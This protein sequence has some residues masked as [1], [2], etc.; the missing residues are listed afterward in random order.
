MCEM[1]GRSVLTEYAHDVPTPLIA[2]EESLALLFYEPIRN[3]ANDAQ[4]LP[5]PAVF[6]SGNIP[7]V[8]TK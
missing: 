4:S 1:W 3:G 6:T 5:E 8:L 2:G 7:D